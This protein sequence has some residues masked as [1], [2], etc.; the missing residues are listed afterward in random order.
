MSLNGVPQFDEV[1]RSLLR[2]AIDMHIHS[3]PDIFP[4]S[5]NAVEAAAQAKEAGMDAIVLKSH[6]TDTAA[7]AELAEALTGMSVTGGVA[8]NYSVG[9]LNPHAVLET[10][11]QGGRVVWFPTL[12]ATHFLD[13][14]ENVPILREKSPIGSPGLELT[15]DKGTLLPEVE[16]ILQLV[17]EH[18]LILCSGHVTPQDALA[19]FRRAHELGITRLVVTHPHAAFVGA[20][21]AEMKEL[22]GLGAMNEMHYAFV[23]AVIQPPQTFKYIADTIRAVGVEHCYLA[24]DGGQQMNPV[25]VEALRLFMVGLFEQGFSEDEMRYMTSDAPRRILTG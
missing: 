24:T 20:D 25:P 17:R 19:A 2:G 10:V 11:R 16:E 12:C 7:R 5:V 1:S 15:D 21:V 6:S 18:D 8:L 14:A 23:T 4:R 9:G 22:A 13:H 3:G